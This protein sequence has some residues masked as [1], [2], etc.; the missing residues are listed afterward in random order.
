MDSTIRIAAIVSILFAAL[1]PAQP[2]RAQAAKF[3]HYRVIDL[4]TLGGTFSAGNTINN[5]G[6]VMGGSNEAGDVVQLAAL[7]LPGKQIPLGTLGGP[8]SD[9]L[10]PVKNDF[11]LISGVS[12]NGKHDPLGE[13]FSCPVFN[14]T[15]GNSCVAF[16][17]RNDKM[18][19]LPGLGGNNS[20][21]GGVNNRGQ[22]VGWAETSVHDSTCAGTSSPP[23]VQ[24]LQFEAVIWDMDDGHWRVHQLAP[25]PGDLDGAAVAINDSGQVV[26]ISGVCSIAIGGYSAIHALLWENGTPIDM[27]NLGG[28]GWNTPG[29][30]NRHGEAAGFANQPNDVSGGVLAFLPEAFT[31]TRERGMV[32]IGRLSGDAI[33]E[34]T[35]IN[36]AGQ[37]VGTSYANTDFSGSRAFVYQNGMMSALNDLLTAEDQTS[38]FV[39]ST[40]GIN[41][42]GEIA[43]TANLVVNG[44][45][46]V[47]AHAVLL[48]P[49]GESD[50]GNGASA[51]AVI[52]S[53][54]NAEMRQRAALR[55]FGR[56]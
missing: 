31:W 10:W 21:G 7:W 8:S 5:L 46:T 1:G 24:V 22:I 14:L 18:T 23:F 47:A 36:D 33:S 44:V 39:S 51:S 41:D 12:E 50:A 52:P 34:A 32:D 55:H 53:E 40:G 25:F 20:I 38:F 3:S 56:M 15:S 6:W 17:W 4:G 16:A 37:V 43:A 2:V 49:T 26:G 19:Q 27:G 35:D 13:T 48:V 54:V 42:A 28:H 30:I 11:G 9:V 45:V 29:A